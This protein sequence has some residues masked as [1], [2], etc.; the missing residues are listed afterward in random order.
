MSIFSGTI[1]NETWV[2]SP[3]DFIEDESDSD[4]S[5]ATS[6][7]ETV[8]NATETSSSDGM[9]ITESQELVGATKDAITSLFQ[10]SQIIR[11]APPS[12]DKVASR[13]TYDHIFDAN[14]VRTKFPVAAEFLVHRLGKA[15][16][17]RREFFQYRREHRTKL[18]SDLIQSGAPK[19]R[20]QRKGQERPDG[21]SSYLLQKSNPDI[22]PGLARTQ[23]STEPTTY[24]SLQDADIAAD[25]TELASVRSQTSFATTEIPQ[26]GHR[27]I[28]IPALGDIY[29]E[30]MK[31]TYGE[32]FECP[33]CYT[34]QCV[35]NRRAW[36]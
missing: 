11:H 25:K 15:I 23:I 35:K 30:G 28:V 31:C 27:P 12:Y 22:T 14:H 5:S 34:I 21:S 10:F 17:M 29:V 36:K 1:P 16:T 13:Y 32:Y 19:E 8:T 20:Q 24:R 18:S 6:R 33:Y 2:T 7:P 3:Q 9:E 26:D 4:R